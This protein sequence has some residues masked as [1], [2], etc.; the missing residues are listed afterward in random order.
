MKYIGKGFEYFVSDG[1]KRVAA[2]KE[3]QFHRGLSK[4][5]FIGISPYG[6]VVRLTKEEIY[7]FI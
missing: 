2:C 6:N 3:I 7:R 5:L 4:P 1:T